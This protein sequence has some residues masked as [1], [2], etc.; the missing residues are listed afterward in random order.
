MLR[1]WL[2]SWL[3]SKQTAKGLTEQAD[4]ELFLLTSF[5]CLVLMTNGICRNALAGRQDVTWER[6][7]LVFHTLKGWVWDL[8]NASRF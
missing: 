3:W 8:R 5:L 1:W 6:E 2:V 7:R 4:N